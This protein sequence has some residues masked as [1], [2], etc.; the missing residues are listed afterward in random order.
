M[1]VKERTSQILED[2]RG[3]YISGADIADELGVTRNAVWKAV[4]ALKKEGCKISAV[5]NKGYCLEKN[6]DVLSERTVKKY[7]KPEYS[8]YLSVCDKV[9]ST[10]TVLKEKAAAGA[11]ESTI[12]IAAE[13]SAGK[14]RFDRK[15]A[16][17][18]SSGVY[19]SILLRPDIPAD[20]A[21]MITTAAAVAV[22]QTAENISGRTAEIKW[23]NDVL[24]D[25]KKICGILTEAAFGLEGGSLDY[26][27]LGIGI[28][29]TE[30]EGGFPDEIKDKAGVIFPGGTNISDI[31]SRVAAGTINAFMDIYKSGS[32]SFLEEY[33]RRSI[34]VGKQVI[35]LSGT[36]CEE[37]LVLDIDDQCRLLVRMPD[38]TE[39]TVSS[40]EISLRLK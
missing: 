25:G 37:A 7:L 21:L 6:S 11:P 22:A 23:V 4:S 12:L 15:F 19:F 30:P 28:N 40:G 32:K 1:T 16:S 17:A 24:M 18:R 3:K 10:N 26:A 8:A 20:A 9:T 33:K 35:L 36:Y 27:V 5:T 34:V 2:N 29:I 13:Q 39:K 31:R 38:G 14:G